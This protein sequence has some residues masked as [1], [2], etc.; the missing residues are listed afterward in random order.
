MIILGVLLYS[1]CPSVCDVCVCNPIETVIVL[2]LCCAEQWWWWL[3]WCW[4]VHRTVGWSSNTRQYCDSNWGRNRHGQRWRFC[5]G[6]LLLLCRALHT[7][8]RI[9]KWHK[10]SNVWMYPEDVSKNWQQLEPEASVIEQKATVL[11]TMFA[12]YC[13]LYSAIYMNTIE[14]MYLMSNVDVG[15]TFH[16]AHC[17]ATLWVT[18]ILFHISATA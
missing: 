6:C 2:S 15:D 13:I 17:I 8:S 7:E 10:K 1:G 11:E 18:I 16:M 5:H 9:C 12:F 3:L 14:N 4:P